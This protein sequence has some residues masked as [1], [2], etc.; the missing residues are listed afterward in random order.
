MDYLSY[1]YWPLI[2]IVGLAREKLK[3]IWLIISPAALQ[4]VTKA[5]SGSILHFFLIERVWKLCVEFKIIPG[6]CN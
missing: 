4:V 5:L 3:K 1:L 6:Q 2:L